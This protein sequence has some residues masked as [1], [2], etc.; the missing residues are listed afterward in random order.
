MLSTKKFEQWLKA[1]AQM[2]VRYRQVEKSEVLA[3]YHS[4]KHV[5]DSAEFQAKKKE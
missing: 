5:V 2:I 3:E 1:Q 4:L